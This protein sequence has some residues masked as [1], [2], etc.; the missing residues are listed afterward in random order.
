MQKVKLLVVEI[1][2]LLT[3]YGVRGFIMSF[4]LI[5][6]NAKSR[7]VEWLYHFTNASNLASILSVGLLSRRVLDALEVKY[8]SN[9][10]SRVDRRLNT[11][12]CSIMWPNYKLLYKN[13]EIYNG[14]N[15]VILRINASLIWQKKCLF[16]PS[17]AASLMN[18][19]TPNEEFVGADAFEN[20]FT[21][22]C[23]NIL[24]TGK[25][26]AFWPTDP[27]AEVLVEQNIPLQYI[28]G[29]ICENED[30]VNKLKQKF[31]EHHNLFSCRDS[32]L[33]RGRTDWYEQKK[34]KEALSDGN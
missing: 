26:R 20:M 17:N 12:S 8:S 19:L 24:R 33:F 5:E 3:I 28:E 16:L 21:D 22:K 31:P 18:V 14:E 27:Q 29:V 10:N 13:K 11:I 25:T 30:T 1:N 32:Y 23:A 7:G 6:K 2:V 34:L 15:Y 9:D 4:D